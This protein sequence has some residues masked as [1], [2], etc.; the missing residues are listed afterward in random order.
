MKKM[1]LLIPF[2]PYL[3]PVAQPTTR[4][5]LPRRKALL[6]QRAPLKM[7]LGRSRLPQGSERRR[8]KRFFFMN[9]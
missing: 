5:I 1:V 8:L 2:V 9:R 4:S 6:K 3:Q 7:Q